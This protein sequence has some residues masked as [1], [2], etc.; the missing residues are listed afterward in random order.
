MVASQLED[1]YSA[2]KRYGNTQCSFKLQQGTQSQHTCNIVIAKAASLV[3]VSVVG[4]LLLLGGAPRWRILVV[5]DNADH[6]VAIIARLRSPAG[7]AAATS[8]GCAIAF[9]QLLCP[10]IARAAGCLLGC[11]LWLILHPSNLQE[12]V[13]VVQRSC[14]SGRLKGSISRHCHAIC[15]DSL[16]GAATNPGSTS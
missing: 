7:A 6:G 11:W 9:F 13:I 8:R 1:H 16:T 5:A 10:L 12:Q 14:Q 15:D 2:L 3:V 4:R